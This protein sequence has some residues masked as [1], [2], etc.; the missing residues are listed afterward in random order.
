MPVTSSPI[1]GRLVISAHDASAVQPSKLLTSGCS[2]NSSGRPSSD[3]TLNGLWKWDVTKRD[4]D[5]GSLQLPGLLERGKPSHCRRFSESSPRP[6]GADE[7]GGEFGGE[8]HAEVFPQHH[9]RGELRQPPQR[10]I[11]PG[12]NGTC[13]AQQRGAGLQSATSVGPA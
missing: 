1:C 11:M 4:H 8:Q 5:L 10:L 6:S 13:L 7:S 3:G 9:F 12:Q 2:G